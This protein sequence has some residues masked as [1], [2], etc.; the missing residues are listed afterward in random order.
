MRIHGRGVRRQAPSSWP[1]APRPLTRPI[2]ALSPLVHVHER[3]LHF[4]GQCSN[5]RMYK[6]KHP[7]LCHKVRLHLR[8]ADS[9]QQPCNL[10]RAARLP[11]PVVSLH[12]ALRRRW[13]RR[14]SGSTASRGRTPTASPQRPPY[15]HG[16][17][18]GA[19]RGVKAENL[20]LG[21]GSGALMVLRV[22]L[23]GACM[24][25]GREDAAQAA[26]VRMR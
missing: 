14:R 2:T 13:R 5:I 26:K 7:F 23:D 18:T 15:G 8:L 21:A 24:R 16:A 4:Y 22:S 10:T 6:R 1:H 9:A 12:G 11:L 17:H 20:G 19:L 25:G 3:T